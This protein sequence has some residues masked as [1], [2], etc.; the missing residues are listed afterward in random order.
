MGDPSESARAIVGH[1]LRSL[2][3]AA[4]GAFFVFNVWRYRE[5][6]IDDAYI[7]LRYARNWIEGHGLV[8]NPGE[9]VE[10]YTNFLWT[11]IGALGLGLGLDGML[12]WK[13]LSAISATL[14]LWRL[15]VLCRDTLGSVETVAVAPWM[16]LLSLEAFGYW[17]ITG[18]ETMLY[19]C[20]FVGALGLALRESIVGRRL[21]SVWIFIALA[22]TRPE[23][24]MV[25]GLVHGVV[26]LTQERHRSALRR[27][28][29]DGLLF[30][31]FYGAYF[32]WRF[33]FYGRP[34]PNTYYAK[35]TGGSEQW[36]NGWIN[37]QQY[38]QSQP[39]VALVWLVSAGQC[40]S[41]ERRP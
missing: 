10:G 37:L 26:W 19:A 41:V 25:F 35:I 7:S 29:E 5:Y 14:L 1:R 17:T 32:A 22:L 34:F 12:W 6:L 15:A 40:C 8:F 38:A 4:A 24:V 20:L 28:V 31:L 11:V 33:S 3:I 21:G 18:M 30:G 36:L 16:F 39:V 2:W 9:V 23:G 27:H 13:S